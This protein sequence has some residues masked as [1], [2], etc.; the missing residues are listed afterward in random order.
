MSKQ[1]RRINIG[2][3]TN[4]YAYYSI[5][6]K[7]DR[8]FKDCKLDELKQSKHTLYEPIPF[9]DHFVSILFTLDY[10]KTKQSF[11]DQSPEAI[12]GKRTNYT[13][14]IQGYFSFKVIKKDIQGAPL[15][16]TSG[17][18]SYEPFEIMFSSTSSELSVTSSVVGFVEKQL[19]F[20]YTGPKAL[21]NHLAVKL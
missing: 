1:S 4:N 19:P 13:D 16:I 20:N 14:F 11:G 2:A 12:F 15:K 17:N 18:F 9:Y 3:A 7:L 5:M 10:Y 21:F 8:Y 6:R